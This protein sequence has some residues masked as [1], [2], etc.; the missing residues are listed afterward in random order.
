MK[1]NARR[2][3]SAILL[4]SMLVSVSACGKGNGEETEPV[5]TIDTSNV[6][7]LN[8]NEILELPEEL[9]YSEDL[10]NHIVVM[11]AE[12]ILHG[13]NSEEASVISQ[14]VYKQFAAT[15]ERLGVT[16]DYV[17]VAPFAQVQG[18]VSQSIN[19]Q[20][21]DY[22]LVFGVSHNILTLVNEG[23]FLPI[24]EL[25]HIDLDK[26]WWNKEYIES[27]S[28]NSDYP[29]ILFGGITYN[30]VERTTCMFFNKR[31]MEVHHGLVDSDIYDMVLDGDWTLDKFTELATGMYVDNG[32]SVN[33]IADFH[34][35]TI[36]G[37]REVEFM[38]FSSGLAFSDRDED[39]YPVL[40]LNTNDSID[41]A[42]KLIGIFCSEDTFASGSNNDYVD[43]KFANGDALFMPSRLFLAGWGSMREMKDDF[44]IIPMPKFDENVDRYYSVVGNAVQWGVVPIT[45]PDPVLISAVAESLAYEGYHRVIPAYYETSLKLKYTRGD[46]DVESQ[47]IDIITQGARTDFLYMNSLG[48]IGG[49]F[50]A[51]YEA[52]QNR[53]ASYYAER[54]MIANANLKKLI[55]NLEAAINE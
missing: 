42:E 54:E 1:K 48:G 53:F 41:L 52:G 24:D 28:L 39:G 22:Q 8:E 23:Y 32:D 55:A 49:I 38:A 10:N 19:A 14:E 3:I 35:I 47:L 6:E 45:V 5:E 29:Y 46:A 20:S 43:K 34:G 13:D 9:D 21:N 40:N 30:N 4:A 11:T 26:I 16:F 25:P 7:Q 15:E 17:D 31:L 50:G 37:K 27:V 51:C 44:G 33:N 12:S 18:L 36:S 2:L